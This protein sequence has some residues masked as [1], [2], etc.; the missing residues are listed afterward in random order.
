MKLNNI[1]DRFWSINACCALNG[2]GVKEGME[3]LSEIIAKRQKI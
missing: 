2:D 1:V 3:W